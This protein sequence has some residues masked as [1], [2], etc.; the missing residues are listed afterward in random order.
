MNRRVALLVPLA[1]A[2]L[3]GVAAATKP[4]ETEMCASHRRQRKKPARSTEAG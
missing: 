3:F 1:L 4:T 2:L